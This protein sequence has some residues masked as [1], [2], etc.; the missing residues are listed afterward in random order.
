M[1]V[2]GQFLG[3]VHRGVGAAGGGI[4]AVKAGQAPVTRTVR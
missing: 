2:A 4:K 1:A 3:P